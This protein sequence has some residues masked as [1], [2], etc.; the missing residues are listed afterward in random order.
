VGAEVDW[1]CEGKLSTELGRKLGETWDG[2]GPWLGFKRNPAS[3]AIAEGGKVGRGKKRKGK[4][5]T[6]PQFSTPKGDFVGGF[7][8]ILSNW[9]F[10][11][12]AYESPRTKGRC[13][14]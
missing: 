14:R 7:V 1:I 13:R 10:G 3:E 8:E 4:T 2:V 11:P 9:C 5:L 12:P 6:P